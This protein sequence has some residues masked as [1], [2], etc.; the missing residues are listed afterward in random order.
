MFGIL[1]SVGP[2]E[3][4]LILAIAL[5]VIG[6]G[7][8]PQVGSSVGRAITEFRK[9]TTDVKKEVQEAVGVDDLNDLKDLTKKL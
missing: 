3:L 7:K 6:P 5:I 1:G 2:W 4:I 8:L 9:A